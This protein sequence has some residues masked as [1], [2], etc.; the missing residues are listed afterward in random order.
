MPFFREFKEFAKYGNMVDM[1]VGVII[2]AAFGKIV[3]SIVSDLF[4]P[5]ISLLLGKA[6]FPNLFINLSSGHYDTLAEAK[7][8]GAA[9]INYGIFLNI[10]IEF[11][12]IMFVLFLFVRQ[13]NRIRRAREKK[14]NEP[15]KTKKCPFC[16]SEIPIEAIK[17][18]NCTADLNQEKQKS[19]SIKIR[20]S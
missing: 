19:Q 9:T 16:S 5:P 1:S 12:I 4:M 8:A 11:T 15:I 10:L 18:P 7:E 3:D 20:M 6:N 17:C 2:G 14:T 13:W